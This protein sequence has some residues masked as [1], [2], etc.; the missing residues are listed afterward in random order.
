MSKKNVLYTI[1]DY[2]GIGRGEKYVFL[3]KNAALPVVR[4]LVSNVPVAKTF[5]GQHKDT[6]QVTEVHFVQIPQDWKEKF[7]STLDQLCTRFKTDFYYYQRDLRP[8][9]TPIVTPLDLTKLWDSSN[10]RWH[11]EWKSMNNKE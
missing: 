11:T 9:S 3:A 4:N 6:N 10:K 8:H 5:R 1:C 2:L 7:E